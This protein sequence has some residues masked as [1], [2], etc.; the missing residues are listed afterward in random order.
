LVCDRG[1][2]VSGTIAGHYD[3]FSYNGSLWLCNVGKDATTTEA[4]SDGNTAWI[5]QVEKGK[6]GQSIAGA[7]AEFYRIVPFVENAIII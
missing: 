4:P 6:D 5:K 7:D 1:E 3:R 2:W